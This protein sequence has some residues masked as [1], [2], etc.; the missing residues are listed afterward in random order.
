[1]RRDRLSEKAHRIVDAIL[2]GN[3]NVQGFSHQYQLLFPDPVG[4][5]DVLFRPEP[6]WKDQGWAVLHNGAPAIGHQ[7]AIPVV[8][9][10]GKPSPHNALRRIPC[11]E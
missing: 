10:N 6:V 9:R 3:K 8:D 2:I 11:S 4:V 1:M 7:V 5:E